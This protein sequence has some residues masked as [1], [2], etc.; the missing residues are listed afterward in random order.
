MEL[1]QCRMCGDEHNRDILLD[2]EQD[3]ELISYYCRIN[4]INNP[5]LSELICCNCDGKIRDF[6]SFS[7]RAKEIQIKLMTENNIQNVKIEEIEDTFF[8]EDDKQTQ[9]FIDE[10]IV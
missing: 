10:P 3:R 6:S 8:Y 9:L 1:S 5:N 2:I 7:E 4:L